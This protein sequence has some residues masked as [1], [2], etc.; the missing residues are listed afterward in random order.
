MIDYVYEYAFATRFRI[1]SP[2]IKISLSD[3]LTFT[4]W[5]PAAFI[6]G[7][8]LL[9]MAYDFKLYKTL[10]GRMFLRCILLVGIVILFG[11]AYDYSAQKTIALIL[12][13]PGLLL[14]SIFIFPLFSYRKI[15]GWRTRIEVSIRAQFGS[16]ERDLGNEAVD[17]LGPVAWRALYTLIPIIAIVLLLG[18][19]GAKT[20]KS[21]MVIKS[22]PE[23]VVLRKYSDKL[24]CSEFDRDKKKISSSYVIKTLDQISESGTAI[25][26]EEIGPLR[27]AKRSKIEENTSYKKLKE[28]GKPEMK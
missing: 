1:P 6:Y 17:K 2:L 9:S 5:I 23:L 12:I 8:G 21:F 13:G 27:P 20:Q 11:Y 14:L 22:N 15:K 24:I 18:A 10:A 19:V 28:A 7:F 16:K 26:A 25:T 4:I 3:L